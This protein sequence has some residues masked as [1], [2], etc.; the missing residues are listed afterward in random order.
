MQITSAA[1]RNYKIL[2]LY[3]AVN[4]NPLREAIIIASLDGYHSKIIGLK[5]LIGFFQDVSVIS[6]INSRINIQ[7]SF[8]FSKFLNTFLNTVVKAHINGYFIID[9]I[10]GNLIAKR[11]YQ[12]FNNWQRVATTRHYNSVIFKILV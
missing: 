5:K 4:P 7:I 10:I 8:K 12:L 9:K 2:V 3:K 11:L 6:E 1:N